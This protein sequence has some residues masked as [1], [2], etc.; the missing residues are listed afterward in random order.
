MC[1]ASSHYP[2]EDLG[3]AYVHVVILDDRLVF[4]LLTRLATDVV[5]RVDARRVLPDV[6][7][8]YDVLRERSSVDFDWLDAFLR[9]S[10]E[11]VDDM[12]RRLA[13]L[14]LLPA[15]Y[16][17]D[18]ETGVVEAGKEFIR[19]RVESVVDDLHAACVRRRRSLESRDALTD[20][21]GLT[22]A[23]DVPDAIGNVRRVGEV[24]LHQQELGLAEIET[25]RT[26][27]HDIVSG[28]GM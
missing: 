26:D 6:V 24:E 14:G 10:P 2:P 22:L 25:F 20:E 15:L 13:G 12:L 19:A 4:G 7:E 18:L 5:N 1:R 11:E 28:S 8:P 21:L 9:T 23:S 27:E 16:I 17:D 3:H